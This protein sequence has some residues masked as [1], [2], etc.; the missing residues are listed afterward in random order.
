M[1][2]RIASTSKDHTEPDHN[3]SLLASFYESPSILFGTFS[4][5]EDIFSIGIEHAV[6]RRNT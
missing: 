2:S 6:S 5:E 1:E 3:H 4:P